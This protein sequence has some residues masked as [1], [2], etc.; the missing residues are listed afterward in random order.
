[1]RQAVLQ[2]LDAI[3]HRLGRPGLETARGLEPA[4][5]LA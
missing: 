2:A 4:G 3:L 1:M 5:P